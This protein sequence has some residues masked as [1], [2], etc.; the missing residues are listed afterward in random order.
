MTA[1]SSALTKDFSLNFH[2]GKL[3]FARKRLKAACYS[4]PAT[5]KKKL[6]KEYSAAKGSGASVATYFSV[7]TTLPE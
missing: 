6:P 7:S 4:Q 5:T 1:P 2:Q 3:N